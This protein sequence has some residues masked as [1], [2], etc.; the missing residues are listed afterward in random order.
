MET[1]F[2]EKKEMDEIK[3]L[4]NSVDQFVHPYD[5]TENN[6]NFSLL[7][8]YANRL[9]ER[10]VRFLLNFKY[11]EDNDGA[12]LVKGFEVDAERI[13]LTPNSWDD[14]NA[15]QRTS[16][17]SL[18]L[19][20]CSALLGDVIGWSTQQNGKI[21]HDIV[22]SR[23]D[24]HKQVGSS[25]LTKLWWHTEEAFHPCRCDY[26][27]LLCLRNN[28]GAATTYASVKSLQLTED[29]KHILFNAKYSI[30][31]DSS[32]LKADCDG[33]FQMAKNPVRFPIL[34]GDFNNPYLCIDPFYMDEIKDET[35]ED[36]ALQKIVTEIENSLQR[37]VL[38]PGDI[39]FLDNYR[40]V[41]GRDP[42]VARYDGTDRWLKRVNVARDLRKS[43]S[44]RSNNNS[45]IIRT[46]HI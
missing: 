39:L 27:G 19:L 30:Y 25:S 22:P 24:E 5:A 7:S 16:T 40:V 15:A 20:F 35:E 9:P 45:R 37:I 34:L 42:Y 26:L 41:H 17:E 38:E 12:C 33:I 43:R 13:G 29:I 11:N 6:N 32:H 44:F 18:F 46:G 3:Q 1:L 21:V 36:R 14:S 23:G 2:I 8:F 28:V 31:P 4:M 10:L